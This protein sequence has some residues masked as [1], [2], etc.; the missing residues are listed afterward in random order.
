MRELVFLLE[1]ES[2]QA[3]LEGLLPRILP[4]G[5]I[6]RFIPF[7]GKQ[8]LEKQLVRRIRLY[9]NPEARF[10]VLRDQDSN[11]DCLAIKAK[12]ARMC[13]EAG[14]P[15]TLVRIACRE[16]ESFYLA[17]LIAV[18]EGLELSGLA[19]HQG[20]RKFRNPDHLGTPSN[21][22]KKLTKGRYQKIGGSRAIGP[23]LDPTNTRSDS[24]RNLVAG[25]C[26]AAS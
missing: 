5:V 14:R 4:A 19:K 24:F 11:P 23:C 10:L 20:N 6:P 1:E 21:E 16:L 18:E 26:K 9:Q 22:L 15:D 8:D 13:Q 17:D 25:I 2:A 7:Q 3:M 12:L